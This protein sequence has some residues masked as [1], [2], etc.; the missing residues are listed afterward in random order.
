MN[1]LTEIEN[2]V[3]I[4]LRD[5]TR[6]DFP[7]ELVEECIRLALAEYSRV[8]GTV[9]TLS[10]LDGAAETSLPGEDAGLI[11]LGAAGY[12]ACSKAADRKESFNLNQQI[13]EGL[14]K[15]GA[16]FMERYK[17]LLNTV[18][19]HRQWISAEVPWGAGFSL[20]A[21]ENRSE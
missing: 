20:S 17:A 12:A 14:L 3:T 10:G 4:L 19:T 15:V 1:Q 21:Q 8:S 6:L 16:G 18:R 7:P 11:V 5:T 2:R 9:E 13:P